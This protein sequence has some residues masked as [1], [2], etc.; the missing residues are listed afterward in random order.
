MDLLKHKEIVNFQRM[1]MRAFSFL[2][3]SAPTIVSNT[4]S[5]N[6]TDAQLKL[7]RKR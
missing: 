4:K 5:P 7:K 1:K 2:Q 6:N 3:D